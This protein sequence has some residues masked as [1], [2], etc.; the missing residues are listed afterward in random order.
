MVDTGYNK[1]S[2]GAKLKPAQ[3]ALQKFFDEVK[4]H[5]N[6]YYAILR[7]DGDR[8]GRVIDNQAEQGEKQ[9]QALSKAL[10]I[11]AGSVRGIVEEKYQ[12]ALVYAGGDDVLALMPLHTVLR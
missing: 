10:N 12:G 9:H 2:M 1:E 5:P 7:A 11:F 3:L 4:V 8:M 6:P